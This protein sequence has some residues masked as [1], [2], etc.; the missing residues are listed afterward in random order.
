[1]L[2]SPKPRSESPV[3]PLLDRF[4]L[5]RFRFFHAQSFGLRS[6]L[7]G[8]SGLVDEA[9]KG[10]KCQ[11][12]IEFQRRVYTTLLGFFTPPAL[13][14]CKSLSRVSPNFSIGLFVKTTPL[15][16]RFLVGQ[17]KADSGN[18][19]QVTQCR[20]LKDAGSDACIKACKV[21]TEAFFRKEIGLNLELEPNHQT[22]SCR[23][24]FSKIN[25]RG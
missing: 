16:F 6:P 24:C 12:L 9:Q 13:W 7:Q 23:L 18:T 14:L 20:F 8:Y 15:V 19:L 3:E 2:V 10:L 4:L 11:S 17:T 25:R 21:P 22:G 5:G 1:M